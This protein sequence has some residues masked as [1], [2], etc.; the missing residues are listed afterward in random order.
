MDLVLIPEYGYFPANIG[1][2]SFMI[3]TQ[4]GFTRRMPVSDA[5]NTIKF[6]LMKSRT[7]SVTLTDSRI[8]KTLMEHSHIIYVKFREVTAEK[9]LELFKTWEKDGL[10]PVL[11]PGKWIAGNQ[12]SRSWYQFYVSEVENLTQELIEKE[13]KYL[14]SKMQKLNIYKMIDRI[15]LVCGESRKIEHH[16]E[17]RVAISGK[18]CGEGEGFATSELFKLNDWHH[19]AKSAKVSKAVLFRNDELCGEHNCDILLHPDDNKLDLTPK[20]LA[21]HIGYKPSLY[22]KGHKY[23]RPKFGTDQCVIHDIRDVDIDEL[24]QI[25]QDAQSDTLGLERAISLLGYKDTDGVLQ[26]PRASRSVILGGTINDGPRNIILKALTT[27][28]KRCF[29]QNLDGNTG[30]FINIKTIPH[31]I[32]PQPAV[33]IAYPDMAPIYTVIKRYRGDIGISKEDADKMMI[34]F[35]GDI[36]SEVSKE[37]CKF[38]IPIDDYNLKK[39]DEVESTS[40]PEPIVAL[41][42]ILA[43]HNAIGPLHNQSMTLISSAWSAGKGVEK[44]KELLRE[45]RELNEEIITS[46]K[47]D[48]KKTQIT[49]KERARNH[50]IPWSIVERE[51]I[52]SRAYRNGRIDTIIET[53]N[54]EQATPTGGWFEWACSHFRGW[55]ITNKKTDLSELPFPEM[56][57]IRRNSFVALKKHIA[58]KHKVDKDFAQN[59]DFSKYGKIDNPQSTAGEEINLNH[60]RE[61]RL[62]WCR[63]Q[64]TG[65][66]DKEQFLLLLYLNKEYEFAE[67]IWQKHWNGIKEHLQNQQEALR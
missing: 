9:V 65:L 23:Q 62:R 47:G 29:K 15:G 27:V 45:T 54:E 52:F 46:F 10:Y 30:A 7:H 17:L 3:E 24:R 6:Q 44:I 33:L 11:M 67:Y 55:K 57:K 51:S 12:G 50:G 26:I 41:A 64:L 53:A 58:S 42:K 38:V 37:H 66:W 5:Y 60:N 25:K 2:M 35:D 18:I 8:K 31:E 48:S 63:R 19:K 36:G 16:G 34:D 22:R 13:D 59:P 4:R 14:W 56:N 40:K 21:E 32:K 39:P 1:R 20:Q 43:E 61:M 49:L 28:A